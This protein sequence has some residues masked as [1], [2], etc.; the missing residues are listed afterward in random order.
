MIII[1]VVKQT[2]STNASRRY[3]LQFDLLI[4]IVV[5]CMPADEQMKHLETP[6]VR[7]RKGIH[8]NLFHA[9]A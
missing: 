8:K 2:S 3:V 6:R 4:I 5:T 7:R 9:T 1:G